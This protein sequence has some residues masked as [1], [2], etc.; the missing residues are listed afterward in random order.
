MSDDTKDHGSGLTD[1][2]A[3]EEINEVYFKWKKH[4]EAVGLTGVDDVEQYLKNCDRNDLLK[5]K[6]YPD[7]MREE[8]Q[9]NRKSGLHFRFDKRVQTLLQICEGAPAMIDRIDKELAI[10]HE[11]I[12]NTEYKLQVP[13][14]MTI[15]VELESVI[16]RA[17]PE[18]L[19]YNNVIRMDVEKVVSDIFDGLTN[20][21]DFPREAFGRKALDLEELKETVHFLILCRR[22]VVDEVSNHDGERRVQDRSA[23][24]FSEPLTAIAHHGKG[25][26]AANIGVTEDDLNLEIGSRITFTNGS[27]AKLLK[28]DEYKTKPRSIVFSPLVNGKRFPIDIRHQLHLKTYLGLQP[29]VIPS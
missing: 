17:R 6:D 4:F 7:K 3:I 13:K 21:N 24:V 12:R 20:L 2:T 9:L 19:S 11:M 22:F 26:R 25:F 15:P 14:G 18:R 28:L 5:F 29:S 1:Q 10:R 23:K 16:L 8:F 27:L